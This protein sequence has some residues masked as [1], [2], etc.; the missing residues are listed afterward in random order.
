MLLRYNMSRYL[1]I[2]LASSIIKIELK[3]CVVHKIGWMRLHLWPEETQRK[4]IAGLVCYQRE[5][6]RH[7]KSYF[8]E[9]GRGGGVGQFFSARIFFQLVRLGNMFRLH[10]SLSTIVL[11]ARYAGLRDTSAWFF[12]VAFSCQSEA[13]RDYLPKKTPQV[14]NNEIKH[15]GSVCYLHHVLKKLYQLGFLMYKDVD[16]LFCASLVD[17]P[18]HI[19]SWIWNTRIDYVSI[20]YHN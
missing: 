8:W 2:L 11:V 5:T 9:G 14:K 20:I 6:L 19:R 3:K 10:D 1:Y 13:L 15:F 12:W 7:G 4:W 18:V 16:E 17:R